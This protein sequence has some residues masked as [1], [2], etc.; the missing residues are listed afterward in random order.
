MTLTT[1]AEVVQRILREQRERSRTSPCTASACADPLCATHHGAGFDELLSRSAPPAREVRE[2][3][4]LA[5][6]IDHTLLR[7]DA[8]VREIERLCREAVEHRFAS[9]CVHLAYASACRPLLEGSAVRLGTVV[10]F[11]LGATSTRVKLFEADEALKS[12]AHELD[13]VINLGMLKNAWYGELA[14]EIAAIVGASHR[15]GAICKVI[16]ETALLSDAE[17]LRACLLAKQSKADFVKT[18]TGFSTRGATEADVALM[19]FAVGPETGVKAS[20]G[21]RTREDAL[22]MIGAGA[23]RIGTSSGVQIVRG[24]PGTGGGY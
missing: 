12:G 24:T 13:M 19:R 17:K 22:K 10:G 7:A 14:S 3:A 8:N 6:V 11:P 18:S 15:G 1:G 16:I 20:G 4:D 2:P 23:N 21:I 5:S 9:V